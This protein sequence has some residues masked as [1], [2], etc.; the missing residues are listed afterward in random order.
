M[1]SFLG[2]AILD[3]C[4]VSRFPYCFKTKALCV[5]TIRA[6]LT[7]HNYSRWRRQRNLKVKISDSNLL[8]FFFVTITFLKEI[9]IFRLYILFSQYR[10]CDNTQEVRSF[11]LFI[12]KVHASMNISACTLFNEQNKGPEL[13]S[14][15]TWSV[16][17][18]Q[19]VQAKKVYCRANLIVNLILL[20]S[21]LF[22]SRIG[23][24]LAH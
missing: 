15:I 13:L 8:F 9:D 7:R 17:G 6:T 12:K 21:K 24:S 19:N 1:A 20:G 10:S 2:A 14:I 22:I 23:S 4:D 18:E 3:N 11:I 5:K 16:L